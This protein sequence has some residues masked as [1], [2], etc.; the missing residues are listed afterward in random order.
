MAGSGTTALATD[1]NNP[2]NTGFSLM[3]TGSSTRGY[4][5]TTFGSGVTTSTTIGPNDFNN[6][7]YDLLN[8][9]A[10][11][12]GSA[13]A[14]ALAG[15]VSGQLLNTTDANNFASY[16]STI[17][18]D[19]FNCHSSRKT[20]MAFGSNSR[21][22]SWASVVTAS[23]SLYHVN[24]DY[25]RWFWNGGGKI[26]ISSSR[27]DGAPSAQNAA[28]SSLLTSAGTQEFGGS[29]YESWG[30]STLL[31]SINSSAPYASNRY[32]IF[33]QRISTSQEVFTLVW[34]DPYVDPTPGEPPLPED[35]VDGTLSYSVEIV[36]PTAGHALTPS[37][38][39]ASYAPSSYNAPAPVGG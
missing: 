16:A 24:S 25:R 38:T 28:W 10:H 33:V 12:N 8:A 1:V 20:T 2:Y 32:Q 21:T 15:T 6:I 35:I 34:E 11:Q 19:R 3:G 31:Y 23:Y 13:S 39:W 27:T 5:Q 36:Y 7:R 22:S 14:L 29:A 26:R 4:G 17:D 9:S 30:S 37:G 18:S